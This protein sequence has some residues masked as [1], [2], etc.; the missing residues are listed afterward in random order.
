MAHQQSLNER[1]TQAFAAR[2]VDERCPACGQ[3][4]DAELSFVLI[5]V[6]QADW[7]PA[8]AQAQMVMVTCTRCGNARFF[9]SQLLA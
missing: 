4:S 8:G 3:T 6:A 5:D 2:H 1:L 7:S 9:G